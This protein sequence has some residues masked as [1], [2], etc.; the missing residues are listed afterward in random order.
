MNRML[1]ELQVQYAG[2]VYKVDLLGTL[3]NQSDW[4]NELHPKNPGFAAVA[5]KFN[6]RLYEVLG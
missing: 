4:A 6:N 1:D 3:P 2:L 5:L